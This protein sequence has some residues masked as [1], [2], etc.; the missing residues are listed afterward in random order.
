MF[1]VEIT[2]ERATDTYQEAI[3]AKD[4]K[5]VELIRAAARECATPGSTQ[6][7]KVTAI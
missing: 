5:H 6:T 1:K 7:I 4:E 3:I 2:E